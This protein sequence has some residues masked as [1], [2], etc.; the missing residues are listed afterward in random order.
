[1][2]AGRRKLNPLVA[3]LLEVHEEGP[4]LEAI[5]GLR[6]KAQTVDLPKKNTGQ[7]FPARGVSVP[8]VDL[9]K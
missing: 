3:D 1:V 4:A 9:V 6:R 5:I 7:L 2:Q 8:K